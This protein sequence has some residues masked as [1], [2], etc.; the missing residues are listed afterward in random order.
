MTI[1]EAIQ[2]PVGIFI[3]YARA[4]GLDYSRRLRERFERELPDS[5]IWRD[6]E[7][8]AAGKR[9]WPQIEEALEAAQCM[10]LLLT[11]GSLNS[12]YTTREWRYC[13]QNAIQVIP[14]RVPGV[15]LN[16]GDVPPWVS[17]IHWF[18]LESDQDWEKF[19]SQLRNPPPVDRI[20]FMA[21][22]I[23]QGFV[24][25]PV[26]YERLLD[27]VL[28]ADQG[29]LTAVS[30]LHGAGGFG[31]TTLAA[32]LC[33]DDR[34]VTAYIDGILWVTLGE[35]PNV[36]RELSSLY[37]ALTGRHPGFES[38]YEAAI[39]VADHL[40]HRRCLLVIDDVWNL[41]HL[42][43]FLRGGNSCRRLITTRKANIAV[44]AE[45]E[46]PVLVDEMQL[47]EATMMLSQDVASE[48]TPALKQLAQRL[49]EWP[50]M[51]ELARAALRS[52][53]RPPKNESF[54]TALRHV[55]KLLERRGIKGLKVADNASR[56]ASISATM[57]ISLENL[58]ASDRQAATELAVFAADLEIPQS[59]L[60]ALWNVDDFDTE[61]RIERLADASLVRQQ[62]EHGT[63]RLHDVVREYFETKLSDRASLHARL[64]ANWGPSHTLPDRF[65]WEWYGYHLLSAGA[66]Q[67]MQ[68]LILDPSWLEA[69]LRITGPNA[70]ITDA[71]RLQAHPGVAQESVATAGLVRDAIRLS[72][73]LT[74]QSPEQFMSQLVGRLTIAATRHPALR[75]L[76]RQISTSRRQPVLLPRTR[77]LS[78]VGDPLVRTLQGHRGAVTSVCVTPNGRHIVSGSEDHALIVWESETGRQV[79]SLGGHSD[80]VSC[81]VVTHAGDRAVSASLDRTI[82]VWDLETGIVTQTFHGHVDQVTSVLVTP[83]DRYVVSGSLDETIKV[84]DLTQGRIIKTL[85]GHGAGVNCVCVTADGRHVVSASADGSLTVWDL[86]WGQP[87]R[88]LVEH[89]G[90]VLA[91][92]VTPDGLRAISA[93]ADRTSKVWDLSRGCCVNT[94]ANNG[95]AVTSLAI[96]RNGRCLVTATTNGLL[97]TWDLDEWRK[98]RTIDD[99]SGVLSVCMTPDGRHA[100]TGGLDQS[101][102]VWDLEVEPEVVPRPAHRSTISSI[103]VTQDGRQAISASHDR[104]LKVWDVESGVEIL[105]LT[106]HVGWVNCVCVTPDA[107]FAI[108]ASSDQT[109]RIW[110]LASASTP[111]AL[112]GHDIA[113]SSVCAMPNGAHA[114]SAAYDK[115]LKVW[116]LKNGQAIRSLQGHEGA[117]TCVAVT[118]DG[119]HVVSG[120]SD[121]TLK[122]WDWAKARE[123]RTMVGHVAEV[124]QVCVTP[125]GAHVVSASTDHTLKV[126]D[127]ASGLNTKTLTG[128]QA[129]VTCVSLTPDG[130][131][132]ISAS[133]DRT[134]IIWR[135]DRGERIST[136]TAESQLTTCMISPDGRTVLVGDS[137]GQLHFF[138]LTGMEEL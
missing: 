10:V 38:E 47:S 40:E 28:H 86:P 16:H 56:Q 32:R 88:R 58:D 4:D 25:R 55:D 118:H 34:V 36:L 82:R 99:R 57:D 39:A 2:R 87:I 133:F 30:A 94:L 60:E 101:L 111:L 59:A 37:G 12:I 120:A 67:R 130:R 23:P 125:D 81:V 3:S 48:V 22:D 93:S 51:L 63:I 66:E 35:V 64:V 95:E 105:S 106:G 75:G 65:A 84:W 27:Q 31:K 69:K 126:W 5:P 45:C 119:Q 134:L 29:K 54:E 77:V 112:K 1:Q 109:L 15:T 21:P 78:Q 122:I 8:M 9:W 72:G 44:S 114:V 19:K 83:D 108:S 52:R 110:Q 73:H 41:A 121:H 17:A 6:H 18:D 85:E 132:A 123:L 102:R 33:H 43:P 117:V 80:F 76:I 129:E 49:G 113:V 11:P 91:V 20:P 100:V 46:A 96:N 136:F 97:T 92:C 128:H 124:T 79:R 131:Y 62:A 103:C 24:E 26:E 137:L 7:A 115:T 116:D 13:R 104:S 14:V 98:M 138:T 42:Q 61:L 90:P 50:L 127:L 89:E 68:D 53:M 135:L 70:L 107:C 71:E 74:A